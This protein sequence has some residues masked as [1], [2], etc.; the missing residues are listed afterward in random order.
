MKNLNFLSALFLAALAVSAAV[1]GCKKDDTNPATPSTPT[2]YERLGKVEAITAVVDKFLSN[3]AADT[4]INARFAGTVADANRLNALRMNLINQIGQGTGG[5]QVYTGKSM[6][7]AHQ[8]MNITQG[9]F[10]ALAGDIVSALDHFSV[11]QKEKDDLLA[12]LGPM[13]SD[14]VGK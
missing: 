1:P 14:I 5:P 11:P 2:L 4:V 8:G 7:A 9:E 3:V 12:I 10:N 13:Q 6:L